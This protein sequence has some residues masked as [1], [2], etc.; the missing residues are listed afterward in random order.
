MRL[1]LFILLTG[2]TSV[3]SSCS[4]T[5]A[6]AYYDKEFDFNTLK[7]YKFLGWQ[8]ESG[9]LV[10]DFDKRRI[11][12]ALQYE[13]DRRGMT[14]VEEGAVDAAVSLFV[15]LDKKT[16]VTAYNNYYGG[17]YGG[18]YRPGWGY[19]MGMSTTNY[20]ESDYIEGTLVVDLFD[21]RS[22][23][24]VWQGVLSGVVEENPNKREK[25]I[26]KNISYLMQKYPV[27]PVKN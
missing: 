1:L 9:R 2:I 8:Q 14:Y 26:S 16:S 4:S 12:D 25:A 3:I 7:T 18:Y 22:K 23:D 13:F 15:V 19:G 21:E 6:T 24:Q 20:V 10:N 5:R 11:Y 17:Y 27:R